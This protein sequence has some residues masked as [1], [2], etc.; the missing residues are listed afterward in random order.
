MADATHALVAEACLIGN[1]GMPAQQ[2]MMVMIMIMLV[3]IML[4][5]IMLVMIMLV[6]IITSASFS[7]WS[8]FF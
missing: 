3:M 7:Y 5:M 1:L 2:V 8:L 6:M 4:V